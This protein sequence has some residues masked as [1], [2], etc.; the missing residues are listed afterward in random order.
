V[1]AARIR[2]NSS[3]LQVGILPKTEPAQIVSCGCVV[4]SSSAAGR[5]FGGMLVDSVAPN[6]ANDIYAR[7]AAGLPLDLGGLKT[8]FKIEHLIVCNFFDFVSFSS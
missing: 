6:S 8:S 1:G 7:K 2:L 3:L 5:D 4:A